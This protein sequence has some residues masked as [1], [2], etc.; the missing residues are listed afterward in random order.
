MMD[1]CHFARRRLCLAALALLPGLLHAQAA[2]AER[3][4]DL[5]DAAA[6]RYTGDVISDAKG[7]S[8][9]GVALTITR[10]GKNLVRISSDYPR[11][12]SVDVPLT[13]SMDKIVQQRGDTAFVLDTA[14]SRLDVSFHNE[15]SWAGTR[16]R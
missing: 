9:S 4:P 15:V 3:K 8:R 16:N 6:G 10:I 2:P 14:Q 13:R 1:A 5:G 11:L 12:P 7:S